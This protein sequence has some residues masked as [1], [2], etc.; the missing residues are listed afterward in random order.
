[1]THTS[2]SVSGDFAGLVR[3][4]DIQPGVTADA[5][6][7]VLPQTQCRRCGFDGCLPYAQAIAGGRAA[8]DRCPPGGPA[9]IARLAA[10]TGRCE[11]P[12]D[13]S[14]GPQPTPHR[15]VI[16]EQHCIGCTKCIQA[17][18]V[19][20]IAGA[21]KFLHV[22]IGEACTGCDL[23]LPPCPVD[24]IEIRPVERQWTDT[25]AIAARRRFHAREQRLAIERTRQQERLQTLAQAKLQAI[26]SEPE[27]ESTRRRRAIV[28]AAII[29]ARER[30]RTNAEGRR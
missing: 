4:F 15:V 25:D 28:Q 16:D 18:P 20:A 13:P 23:C 19:D 1:M 27:D 26:D 21:V 8:I 2:G 6:D 14:C 17:C 9:V 5:I 29:R 7:A 10:L 11:I 22:V 3:N 12:P 30:V 24:C